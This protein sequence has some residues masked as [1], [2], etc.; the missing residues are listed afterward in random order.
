MIPPKILTQNYLIAVW[1]C[2]CAS[3]LSTDACF[4]YHFTDGVSST[5]VSAIVICVFDPFN[6]GVTQRVVR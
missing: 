2:D 1:H 5:A 3:H 4:H 6:F